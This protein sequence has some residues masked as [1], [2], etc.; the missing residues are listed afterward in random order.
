MN[1]LIIGINGFLG[2]NLAKFIMDKKMECHIF[3]TYN[4]NTDYNNPRVKI[5]NLNL[6]SDNLEKEIEN[7]IVNNKINYIIHTAAVKHIDICQKDPLTALHINTIAPIII[8]KVAKRN[9]ISNLIAISSDK[10]NTLNSI[11]SIS[12]YIMEEYI[13]ECGYSIYRGVNFFWSDGSVLD[14]W[15]NQIKNNEVL[16]LRDPKQYRYFNTI[17][18]ICKIIIE[19]ISITGKII[20]PEDVYLVNM[21]DLFNAFTEYFNYHKY[22]IF[23]KYH[24]E[25]TIDNIDDQINKIPLSKIELK[26]LIDEKIKNN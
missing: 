13:L 10:V 16:T 14:I 26:R 6:L 20:L 18:Q 4:Q 2:R 23:E 1:I 5:Y 11:Y 7:I 8:A 17:G 22:Q 9:N 15:H 24:F 3:G 19:N 21:E 12:K 25:N